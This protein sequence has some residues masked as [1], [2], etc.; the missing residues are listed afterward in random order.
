VLGAEIDEIGQAHWEAWLCKPVNFEM[1]L[2]KIEAKP[3]VVIEMG[4]HPVMAAAV[5]ARFGK[6]LVAHVASMRRGEGRLFVRT[7]RAALPTLEFGLTAALEKFTLE[8]PTRGSTVVQ[9]SVDFAE[10]GLASQQLALLASELSGFFPGLAAHDLYRFTSLT[11]LIREWDCTTKSTSYSP[12]TGSAGLE[13]LGCA[14]QLPGGVDSPS[15]FWSLLQNDDQQSAFSA[16]P[17][18]APAAAYLNPRFGPQAAMDAANALGCEGAEAAALDPQHAFALALAREMWRDAGETATA[19]AQANPDRV[20][21]YIGAWQSA[22]AGSSKASAYRTIG[23]S[24]SALASRVANAY[25]LQGPTVT[26]NTACSSALV[27]VDNAL[28]DAKAGRIDFAI[29]G[30]VNLFG[31]EQT[32]FTDLSRAGMLSRTSRCHTFSA[33]ADGYVRAEGGVLMLL[34]AGSTLPSRARILGSAVTQNSTRKP[35]SAVDPVAQERV[36]NL[37]CADAGIR[38]SDL[39]AVEMHGTGTPLGDPVEVSALARATSGRT[40]P[41]CAVTAAKMH[42]GHLESAAGGVGLLKAVL[43]CEQRLVPGFTVDDALNS[44]VVAAMEG[45]SLQTPGIK[46]ALDSQS[47]IG[48]S[49]FGF[50]GS[51]AHIIVAPTASDRAL[52]RYEVANVVKASVKPASV[53][54]SSDTMTKPA[55][56]CLAGSKVESSQAIDVVVKAISD[57]GGHKGKVDLDVELA[58]LG[59]DS[60]GL[61]ELLGRMEDCYGVGCLTVDTIMDHPTAR[62]L[63]VSLQR[64]SCPIRLQP[65]ILHHHHLYQAQFRRPQAPLIW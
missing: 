63:P 65:K 42:V 16:V 24:L 49:S 58:E 45:S 59:V 57:I 64:R 26:V 8:L 36:I 29:V 52:P 1:A 61:A 35:L 12:C 9:Q 47:L 28:R 11:K 7:Q 39:A 50:A 20:G 54:N 33:K 55:V 5:R 15:A 43:M 30:G 21:V 10:Q 44:Q 46:V 22:V 2:A 38:P 34:H 13:V 14:A 27:A 3:T 4:A 23:S 40:G 51:N 17:K 32:L 31:E 25:N 60:L 53:A 37:A 6:D 19:A 48:V 62:G 18:G 41:P 56:P